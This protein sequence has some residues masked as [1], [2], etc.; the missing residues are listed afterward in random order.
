VFFI[1]GWHYLAFLRFPRCAKIAKMGEKLNA[2][3]CA[4]RAKKRGKS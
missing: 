2:N 3:I 1:R 4:K